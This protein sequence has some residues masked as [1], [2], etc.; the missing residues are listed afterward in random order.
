MYSGFVWTEE[1][2]SFLGVVEPVAPLLNGGLMGTGL[3]SLVFA[4]GLALT[5]PRR[6][7]LWMGAVLLAIGSLALAAVGAFPRT[8][9][10]PHD[11]ASVAFYV[12]VTAALIMLGLGA[13]ARGRLLPGMVGASAGL[14]ML[15]LQMLPWPWHGDAIPQVLACLPWSLWTVVAGGG[16]LLRGSPLLT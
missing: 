15:V 7:A 9:E 2:L 6:I 13:M 16:L 4:L 12:S 1:E 11:A 5:L 10:A 3:L 14:M 8:M